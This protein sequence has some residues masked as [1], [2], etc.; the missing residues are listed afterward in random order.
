MVDFGSECVNI[1]LHNLFVHM[2]VYNEH[3]FNMHGKNI[4]VKNPCNYVAQTKG[5]NDYDLPKLS[6][7]VAAMMARL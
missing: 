7:L 5:P 6:Q 4:K 3:L 2:L 1:N